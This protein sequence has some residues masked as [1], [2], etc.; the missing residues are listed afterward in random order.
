MTSLASRFQRSVTQLNRLFASMIMDR[1][2]S[3]VTGTQMYMLHYIRESGKCRLTELADKLEVKP[4]AVTVMID[5][6]EKA[7]FVKRTNDP[8]DRRVILVELTGEGE[9][10]LNQAHEMREQI[11]GSYLNKLDADEA[12]I[13]TD[14]LEKMVSYAQQADD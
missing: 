9:R 3:Q 14:V 4:S 1:L 7:E 10:I 5:R 12:A 13:A 6:L 8:A 2:N 11:I